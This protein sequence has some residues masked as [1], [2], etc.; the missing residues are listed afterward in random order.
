MKGGIKT[1]A[2]WLILGVIIIGLAYGAFG[3]K[4]GKLSY[5]E[6]MSKVN[7]GEVK[8]IVF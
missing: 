4:D 5:S 8:S 7:S 3:N 1:V 2:T 6:L